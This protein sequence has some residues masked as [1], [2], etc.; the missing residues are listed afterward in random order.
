MADTHPDPASGSSTTADAND[1]VDSV[2][3]PLYLH[4]NDHPGLVIISTKL[5]GSNNYSS[6]KR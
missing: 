2:H 1:D 3:H 6:W 4:K 5:N